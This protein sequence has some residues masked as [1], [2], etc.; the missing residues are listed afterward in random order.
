M[1]TERHWRVLLFV[2]LPKMPK[3]QSQD[4]YHSGLFPES[5]LLPIPPHRLLPEERKAPT[6]LS[7]CGAALQELL[8]GTGNG[9]G[10]HGKLFKEGPE[11]PP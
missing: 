6:A 10:T 11:V 4:S 1:R 9:G 7:P 3:W 5:R 8:P 2:Y